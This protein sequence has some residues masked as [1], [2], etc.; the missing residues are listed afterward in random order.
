MEDDAVKQAASAL[1]QHCAR[2]EGTLHVAIEQGS[3]I[4][5]RWRNAVTLH[6]DSHQKPTA[7][8][9]TTIESVFGITQVYRTTT[10]LQG[11]YITQWNGTWT[12]R[13]ERS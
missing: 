3:L 5:S 7:N 11:H 10:P 12:V 8:L 2:R 1:R 9:L 4:V 6:L 13:D